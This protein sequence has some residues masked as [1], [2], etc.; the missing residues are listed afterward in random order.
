MAVQSQISAIVAKQVGRIQGELEARVLSEALKITGKF[1]NEC[2]TVPG[3][4]AVILTK[5]ILLTT[6]NNFSKTTNKFKSLANRLLP[7]I[8]AAKAL[9]QLLK[10]DPTPIAIGTPPF[11]DWGGLISSKTAGM[12]NSSA[13][14]LRKVSKLLE[15]VEDDVA[16]IKSLVT[17]VDPSLN[18]TRSALNTLDTSVINCIIDIVN[19]TNNDE[20]STLFTNIA[21]IEKNLNSN[22]KSLTAKQVE[23]KELLKKIQPSQTTTAGTANEAD[24]SYRGPQGRVYTLEIINITQESRLVPSQGSAISIETEE[25]EVGYIAPRRYA[26]A[27]D[28]RGVVI[29]RGPSSFSADTQILLDELKFRLDNQLG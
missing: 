5:N 16:S 4:E 21:D 19:S 13:D 15:A 6:V 23:V 27:K 29:L 25:V 2:P 7:V 10:I 3:L 1:A 20:T 17:G 11:K 14:R 26:Q 24:F 28:S 8:R 9:I 22:T 12:Q 18:K